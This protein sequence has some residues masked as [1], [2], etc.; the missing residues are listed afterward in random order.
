D[1]ATR[2]PAATESEGTMN[3]A[4][5]QP[6]SVGEPDM[7]RLPIASRPGR[8][9]NAGT[10]GA[11]RLIAPTTPG[12]LLSVETAAEPPA[13]APV[14]GTTI[15]AANVVGYYPVVLPSTNAFTFAAQDTN[16]RKP[17]EI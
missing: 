2:I 4:T 15:Y 7:D 9:A 8:G 3:F 6:M 1:P 10:K 11:S 12:K 13:A 17:A 5:L 14:S 16:L